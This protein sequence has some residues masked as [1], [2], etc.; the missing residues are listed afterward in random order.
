MANTS[1]GIS[2]S[3]TMG[4]PLRLTWLAEVIIADLIA[5][6]DHSVCVLPRSFGQATRIP[7]PS[8]R[9]S[10]TFLSQ[11]L[12]CNQHVMM[13]AYDDGHLIGYHVVYGQWNRERSSLSGGCDFFWDSDRDSKVVATLGAILAMTVYESITKGKLQG[14]Y[15]LPPKAKIPGD[16]DLDLDWQEIFSFSDWDAWF[17]SFRLSSRLKSILEGVFYVAWWRIWR[18]RNQLVFDASPPNRSTIFDDINGES[19]LRQMMR[20]KSYDTEI[21]TSQH[22]F[23]IRHI[24]YLRKQELKLRSVH[25][26]VLYT[27]GDEEVGT[28][29]V[30]VFGLLGAVRAQEKDDDRLSKAKYHR[31]WS[32]KSFATD[33]TH[34]ATHGLHIA[35]DTLKEFANDTH[36]FI[37]ETKTKPTLDNYNNDEDNYSNNNNDDALNK[38]GKKRG[39]DDLGGVGHGNG[40]QISDDMNTGTTIVMNSSIN[41]KA[42]SFKKW[43]LTCIFKF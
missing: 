4:L 26:Q 32:W 34:A 28:S 23:Q 11:L 19:K 15:G 18:L 39:V 35:F 7:I 10:D 13:E 12:L 5:A 36:G 8:P 21:D 22:S 30:A 37:L 2:L 43:V 14:C 42:S 40:G 41:L 33:V 27:N 6:G 9:M 24:L 17:L 38:P 31:Y 25:G 3:S 16:L 29:G 20:W 1:D